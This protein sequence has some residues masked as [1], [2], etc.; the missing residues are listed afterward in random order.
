[1]KVFC[2]LSG[3]LC[4]WRHEW[5]QGSDNDLRQYL[6]TFTNLFR[7]LNITGSHIF[8][9]VGKFEAL[10]SLSSVIFNRLS[11]DCFHLPII[12]IFVSTSGNLI[13]VSVSVYI[14]LQWHQRSVFIS[15]MFYANAIFPQ[16]TFYKK[17]LVFVR[18]LQRMA[19]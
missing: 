8:H 19:L 2:V 5:F 9:S 6:R 11:V 4:F 18:S 7:N 12:Q 14:N 15:V 3:D 13:Q 17:V 10:I 1:M 16:F